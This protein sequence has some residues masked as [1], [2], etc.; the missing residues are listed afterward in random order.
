MCREWWL[1]RRTEERE[2]SGRLWD[3]L[4]HARPLSDR[5]VIEEEAAVT[6]EKREPTPLAAQH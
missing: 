3:E 1:R 2:A 5:D 4:E 6:L